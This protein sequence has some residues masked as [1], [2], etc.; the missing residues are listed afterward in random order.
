MPQ[1]QDGERLLIGQGR[2]VKVRQPDVEVVKASLGRGPTCGSDVAQAIVVTV[3]AQH[4]PLG[5]IALQ[6][7]VPVVGPELFEFGV[8]HL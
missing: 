6:E 5:R 2:G 3:I 7:R 1:G 8:R 4:R